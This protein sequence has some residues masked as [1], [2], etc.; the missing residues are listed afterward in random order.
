[1]YIA[2]LSPA[3]YRGRLVAVTQFNIVL[4]ILLAFFSNYFIA[5]MDLGA[6]D[7]RWMFG[8]EAI[9]A[10]AFFLLL[11]L[12]PRSPDGWWHVTGSRRRRP[13]SSGTAPTRETS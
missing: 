8:V 2:E 7:W 5:G 10:F 3:R 11:F 13:C 6:I 12:V 1:M 9:P 4:G